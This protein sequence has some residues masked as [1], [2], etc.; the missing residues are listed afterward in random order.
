MDERIEFE[1]D[2]RDISYN[3]NERWGFSYR[4]AAIIVRG[5]RLLLQSPVGIDEY[6]T[7]G[8]QIMFGETAAQA[9]ERELMEEVGVQAKVGEFLA[10]G[11][12]F[13]P[14][15]ERRIQQVFLQFAAEIPDDALV[16]RV[17]LGLELGK[18][19]KPKLRFEWV[20]ID[21]LRDIPLYPPQIADV[22]QNRVKHYLY[23]E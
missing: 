20:D 15:G 10:A 17:T 6:A 2:K 22:A 12:L 5:G 18:D 14:V 19:G 9:I 23:E 3:A 8:G 7:P 16:D 11:E 4:A 21:K 13:F 1:Y